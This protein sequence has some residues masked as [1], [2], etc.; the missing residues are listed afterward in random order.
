MWYEEHCRI[1]LAECCNSWLNRG[2]FV[3]LYFALFAFY[4]FYLICVILICVFFPVFSRTSNVNGTVQSICPDT[5]SLTRLCASDPLWSFHCCQMVKGEK[6]SGVNCMIKELSLLLKPRLMS[7]R[8]AQYS[9]FL[10]H[11]LSKTFLAHALVKL[12]SIFSQFLST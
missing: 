2:S 1:N 4:E 3:L 5:N 7:V 8:K 6:V 10:W 9:H 11:L 12:Q